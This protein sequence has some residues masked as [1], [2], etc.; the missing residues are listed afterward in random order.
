MTQELPFLAEA[1]CHVRETPVAKAAEI[2]A[3][4]NFD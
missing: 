1:S 3:G 4:K 2:L